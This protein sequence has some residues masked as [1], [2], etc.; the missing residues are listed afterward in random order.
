MA[1]E[2]SVSGI[3]LTNA[4]YC[5]N[6]STHVVRQLRGGEQVFFTRDGEAIT[7][8][9]G[10]VLSWFSK[11]VDKDWTPA[12]KSPSEVYSRVDKKLREELV[13]IG[14]PDNADLANKLAACY[15]EENFDHISVQERNDI[16]GASWKLGVRGGS[17][18]FYDSDLRMLSD[19]FQD[20]L[21]ELL[22]DAVCG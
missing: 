5:L 3:E 1:T 6:Q 16:V 4:M 12:R 13:S 19:P 20:I 8:Y 14:L 10:K 17:I 2:Q 7:G 15:R 22:T 9:I 18:Y 21:E 11:M